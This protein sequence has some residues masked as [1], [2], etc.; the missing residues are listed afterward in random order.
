MLKYLTILLFSFFLI[1]CKKEAIKNTELQLPPR[2]I[3][4]DTTDGDKYI[5]ILQLDDSKSIVNLSDNEIKI[6]ESL[7]REQVEIY[8]GKFDKKR[9]D[10][11]YYKRQY[12]PQIDENGDK[13]IGIFC[14]CTVEENNKWKTE[15]MESPNDGGECYFH[16]LINISKKAVIYFQA[17]GE[18]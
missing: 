11:R 3:S 18:A 8:N 15:E 12:F 4:V 10:L 6:I 16:V 2:K 14:F 5:A 7:L 1:S 9:I 17:N 13:L